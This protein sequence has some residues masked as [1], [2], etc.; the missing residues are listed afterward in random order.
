MAAVYPAA[1]LASPASRLSCVPREGWAG[2]RAPGSPAV[3]GGPA[4]PPAPQQAP[5]WGTRAPLPPQHPAQES[6]AVFL[7]RPCCIFIGMQLC[8]LGCAWDAC[9]FYQPWSGLQLEMI[10]GGTSSLSVWSQVW[11]LS[12]AGSLIFFLCCL[13]QKV[14]LALGGGRTEDDDNDNTRPI[15]PSS[16][17]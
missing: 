8:R 1:S 17:F 14:R 15:P 3:A 7:V 5:N 12:A 2:S 11:C 4:A 13:H 10:W 6:R 16:S 9:G